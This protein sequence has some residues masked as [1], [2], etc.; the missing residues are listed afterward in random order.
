V[1]VTPHCASDAS[2]WALTRYLVSFAQEKEMLFA[3]TTLV[4]SA[5]F[6]KAARYVQLW[7]KLTTGLLSSYF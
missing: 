2:L 1:I 4:E 6:E 7:A 3:S 5:T